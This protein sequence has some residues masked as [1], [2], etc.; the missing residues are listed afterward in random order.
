MVL[1]EF[2]LKSQKIHIFWGIGQQY[3]LSFNPTKTQAL[4]PSPK[5]HHIC[6]ADDFL[7]HTFSFNF[8]KLTFQDDLR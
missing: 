1:Q 4:R 7:Q 3:Q 2:M 8:V 5:S 6:M